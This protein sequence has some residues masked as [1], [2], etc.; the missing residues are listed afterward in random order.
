[1]GSTTACSENSGV[2]YLDFEDLITKEFFV[3]V[4]TIAVTQSSIGTDT[5]DFGQV[6]NGNFEERFTGELPDGFKEP[7]AA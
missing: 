7:L 1:M 5:H 6:S 4:P 3:S 2:C